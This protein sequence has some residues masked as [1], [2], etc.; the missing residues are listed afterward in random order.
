MKSVLTPPGRAALALGLLFAW[1]LSLPRAGP[2]LMRAAPPGLGPLSAAQSFTLVHALSLLLLGL[3]SVR[4]P[5]AS[6]LPWLGAATGCLGLAL[7]ALPAARWTP[8]LMAAGA[9][10]AAGVLGIGGAL[11]S[12]GP[13]ERPWC[14][15]LGALLANLPLYVTGQPGMAWLDRP[16][17]L[18]LALGPLALPWLLSAPEEKR[19]GGPPFAWWGFLPLLPAV[20]CVYLVGGLMYSLVLPT[21]GGL[22][23]RLGALPYMA[24]LP[25]AAWATAHLGREWAGR[26]GLTLLGLGFL[27][28]ALLSGQG[29]D[30]CGQALVVGGYAF[31]DVFLWNAFA[32]RAERPAL[33][34]G[35]GLGSMVLAI[36]GGMA[37]SPW[38][39]ELAQAREE[40]AALVAT[41][42]LLVAAALLPLW[43]G[44]RAAPM[45][46]APAPVDLDGW[47]LSGREREVLALV[48]RGLSNKEVARALGVSPHTV[49][50]LLE[51][52]YRKMGVGSRTEAISLLQGLAEQRPPGGD[53][54]RG[55]ASLSGRP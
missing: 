54:E 11:A 55:E 31:L 50:K 1:L 38:V 21:L 7:A 19:E 27:G 33:A 32:E 42:A 26:G 28:W 39:A 23:E 45:T 17:A 24:L 25:A 12:L 51:R 53:G 29:R 36:F 9:A 2:L 34:F 6:F 4:L 30:L 49:R 16:F 15:A 46:P 48:A 52:A 18:L 47:G 20:F 40:A 8:L 44:G 3:L 37:L 10:S 22:G 35:L 43:Q 41:A 5:L 14:I 13:K